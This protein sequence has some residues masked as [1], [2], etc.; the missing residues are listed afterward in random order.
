[1]VLLLDVDA[2]DEDVEVPE[3]EDEDVEVPEVGEV[4]D[5]DGDEEVEPQAAATI[6]SPA[7]EAPTAHHCRSRRRPRAPGP[8]SRWRQTGPHSWAWFSASNGSMSVSCPTGTDPGEVDGR[9]LCG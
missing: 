3:V 2:E 7:T 4:G 6:A 5:E 1:M 8:A 9:V